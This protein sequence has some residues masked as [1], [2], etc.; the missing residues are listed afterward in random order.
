MATIITDLILCTGSEQGISKMFENPLVY[1]Y[2]NIYY[3][4]SQQP[5]NEAFQYTVCQAEFVHHD[6]V[7]LGRF[8]SLELAKSFIDYKQSWAGELEKN[9]EGDGDIRKRWQ[10]NAD[11]T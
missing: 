6:L 3:R 11:M 8:E 9:I 10:G 5:W 7:Y 1:K 4:G 2:L